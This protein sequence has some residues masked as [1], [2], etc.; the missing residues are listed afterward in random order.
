M[1]VIAEIAS[2]NFQEAEKITAAATGNDKGT[3]SRQTR[4]WHCVF[5][6]RYMD[7]KHWEWRSHGFPTLSSVNKFKSQ[8]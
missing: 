7:R 2:Y 5:R 1:G 6:G 4:A 3:K 8:V